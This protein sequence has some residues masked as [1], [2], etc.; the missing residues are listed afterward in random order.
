MGIVA[1]IPLASAPTLAV[2]LRKHGSTRKER[3]RHT[4]GSTTA[5]TATVCVVVVVVVV[6]RARARL[7]VGVV[8]RQVAAMGRHEHDSQAAAVRHERRRFEH[9]HRHLDVWQAWQRDVNAAVHDRAWE[10]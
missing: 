10:R 7:E 2:A 1:L 6:P 4:Q 5:I 8:W 9:G 3:D